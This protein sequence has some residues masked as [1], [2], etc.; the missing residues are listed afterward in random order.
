MLSQLGDRIWR[1]G[2]VHQELMTF[3]G[4]TLFQFP[5]WVV[6]ITGTNGTRDGSSTQLW[7]FQVPLRRLFVRVCEGDDCRLGKV[8][9]ANLKSDWQTGGC[10]AARNGDCG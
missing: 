3:S 6:C 1:H 8:S 4:T 5:K 2:P 10:E 7:P 9:A